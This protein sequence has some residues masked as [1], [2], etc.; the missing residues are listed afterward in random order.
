MEVRRRGWIIIGFVE[1]HC[2]K[3]G[4]KELWRDSKMCDFGKLVGW[5]S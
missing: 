1:E 2:F 4:V 3:F 5:V